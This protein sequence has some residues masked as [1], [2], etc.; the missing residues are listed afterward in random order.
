MGEQL[1]MNDFKK[2]LQA[3]TKLENATLLMKKH[4][5]IFDKNNPRKT[6]LEKSDISLI[7]N[8]GKE[9]GE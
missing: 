7:K 9:P 8:I 2:D 3:K 4:P 6:A 1:I 5:E